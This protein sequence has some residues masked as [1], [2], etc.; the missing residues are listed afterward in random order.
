MWRETAK[1]CIKEK[2]TRELPHN[3][4]TK[5]HLEELSEEGY[6][7]KVQ[8]LKDLSLE[9]GAHTFSWEVKVS[10]GKESQVSG[11][12]RRV[13]MAEADPSNLFSDVARSGET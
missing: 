6:L 9:N 4:V 13:G 1:K 2:L 7:A 3:L 11:K 8:S 10:L 5:F 12:D